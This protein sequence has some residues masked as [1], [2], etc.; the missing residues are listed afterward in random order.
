MKLSPTETA[1]SVAAFY[2][3][4]PVT[5][6][7][8]LRSRLLECAEA[9]ALR[10][11]VLV[12]P[13]GINGT[14]AGVRA[15]LDRFF[16]TVRAEPGMAGVDI[17]FSSADAMPFHRLKVRLKKEIV[18]MGVA[19]LDAAR[20]AGVHVPPGEW[21][22][23]VSDPDTVVI[24][25]RNAYETAIGTFQGALDPETE[26]F[27]DFPRWAE[28]NLDRFK[29]KRVAMFCT[30]GIRCEKASAYLKR[31]GVDEVFHLKGG[32]LKYLEEVPAENSLWQGECFVFDERVGIRHGLEQGETTLCRACRHPLTPEE[33]QSRWFQEGVSCPHCHE[34]RT[35]E[36]RER[37]AERQRQVELADKRGSGPHI[38]R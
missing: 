29:D 7:A 15:G 22:A 31:I 11:T 2:R 19:D 30:G 27:R 25:T 10:G 1:V 35:D 13:E 4:A 21:N 33:R 14:I 5:D 36:D 20:E 18:T 23:L 17:K 16:E 38:G 12:A 8:A 26:S 24:D 37:Y 9:E 28:E 3:F 32:I 34:S 6:P